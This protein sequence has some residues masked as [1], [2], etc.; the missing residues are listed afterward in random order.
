[1]PKS[2]VHRVKYEELVADPTAAVQGMLSF[3]GLPFH[4]PCTRP[5]EANTAL[6]TSGA[7]EVR[8]PISPYHGGHDGGIPRSGAWNRYASTLEPLIN[9]L[10]EAKKFLDGLYIKD[11]GMSE[12]S[13]HGEGLPF[14]VL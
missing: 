2:Q 1:M 3:L 14:G 5:H 9:G 11:T 4:D 8:E 10:D 12:V 13:G 7:I 6:V